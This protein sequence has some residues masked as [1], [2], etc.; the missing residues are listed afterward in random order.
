MILRLPTLLYPFYRI[1]ASMDAVMIP[2]A[3]AFCRA[4]REQLR[5]VTVGLTK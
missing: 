4:L 3:P 5:G 1:K 2:P